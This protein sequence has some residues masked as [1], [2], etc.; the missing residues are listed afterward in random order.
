MT[1]S[2]QLYMNYR[3]PKTL[4]TCLRLLSISAALVFA[5]VPANAQDSG[6]EGTMLRGDRAE[7]S[8]TLRDRSGQPVAAQATIRVLREGVPT[9]QRQ[10][11]HGRA[12]FI[13]RNLGNYTV[14][15]DASG[16]KPVEKELSV[17]VAVKAEV[18]IYLTR[19]SEPDDAGALSTKPVLAPKAKEAFDKALKAIDANKMDDADKYLA[20]AFRLAPGH[21]DVLFVQGVLFLNRR[22]WPEAQTALERVI[23]LDASNARAFAAL[24]MALNN[25]SKYADAVPMFEKSVQLDPPGS[26]ETNL[27]LAKAYYYH[28]QYDQ[29]LKT[30]QQAL[31][32]SNGKAP[33]IELVVAQSLTAVGRYE[34]AAGALRKFLKDHSDRPEAATAKRWLDGLAKN[35]KIRQN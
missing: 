18:D 7:L 3:I 11:D 32:E 25:Q 26:W 17:T 27:P 29:A 24:G 35:G 4:A 21:P 34:D 8:V 6:A 19:A 10:A 13:L 12:F 16:Y 28:E 14:V 23:Q 20:E 31:T 2:G 30:S 9:D 15:V 22:N 5:Y 33:Q 1:D